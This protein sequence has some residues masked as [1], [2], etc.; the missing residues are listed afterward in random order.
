MNALQV[1]F[2]VFLL[3]FCP[4]EMMIKNIVDKYSG[5]VVQKRTIHLG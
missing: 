3:S 2:E 1:N 4:E 5:L